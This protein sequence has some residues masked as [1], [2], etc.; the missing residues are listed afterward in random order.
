MYEE[1]WNKLQIYID[2]LVSEEDDPNTSETN[3]NQAY[4]QFVKQ[5]TQ[6]QSEMRNEIKSRM[7]WIEES[8]I[9]RKSN[10]G[11]RINKKLKNIIIKNII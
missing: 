3:L 9:H 5:A 6:M 4:E 11:K 10:K 8:L 2:S 7:K 1:K